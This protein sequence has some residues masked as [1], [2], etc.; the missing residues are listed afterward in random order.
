MA[1]VDGG[2]VDLWWSMEPGR[3]WWLA[4]RHAG[5]SGQFLHV[6]ICREAG[7]VRVAVAV[8]QPRCTMC[9][10]D[11]GWIHRAG[12]DAFALES[13]VVGTLLP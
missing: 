9:E 6:A 11:D 4:P 2:Y 10:G 7:F 1:P 13:G 5:I 12:W 8:C 3:E